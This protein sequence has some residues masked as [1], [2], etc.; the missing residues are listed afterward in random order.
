MTAFCTF[1]EDKYKADPDRISATANL[2]RLRTRAGWS[3]REI[4]D[5]IGMTARTVVRYRAMNRRAA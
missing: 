5:E 3:A 2:V 4:A 1:P